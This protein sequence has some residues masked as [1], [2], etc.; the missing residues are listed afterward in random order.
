MRKGKQDPEGTS[1]ELEDL[2]PTESDAG[3][4]KGGKVDL[5]YRP[6]KP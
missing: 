6:T 3:E 2:E 5:E 4:V 1:E